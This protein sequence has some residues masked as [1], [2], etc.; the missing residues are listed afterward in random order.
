MRS[1][2]HIAGAILLFITFAYLIN[3]N[4]I[5]IGIF[6]AGWI[7]VFPDIIDKLIGKHRGYGHSLIWLIPFFLISIFNVSIAAALVMGFISHIFLDILTV[8]GCPILYPVSKTNFVCFGKKR[9]IKTGTAQDKAVFVFIL[10]LLI[11]LLLFMTNIGT[12]W[13]ALDD[14]NLVSATGGS[15]TDSSKNNDTVKNSFNLNFQIN[16]NV[17][18]NI[19]VEKVS[20]NKT[21]ITIT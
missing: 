5:L 18:K 4:N 1:Y 13:Q 10:F 14:Q 3:L 9:R 6:F 15:N 17:K 12:M 16:Q 11:P 20:D 2:T 7:S 8:N 19:T 21:T